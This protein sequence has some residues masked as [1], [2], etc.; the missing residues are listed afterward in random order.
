[1]AIGHVLRV[2]DGLSIAINRIHAILQEYE[3]VS[4]NPTKQGRRRPWIRFERE[5][6]GVTVHMDCDP[7]NLGTIDDPDLQEQYAA[8]AQRMQDTHDPDD[9]I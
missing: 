1:M 4:E 9:V 8:E 5:Y 6:S 2:R 3:H 7:D